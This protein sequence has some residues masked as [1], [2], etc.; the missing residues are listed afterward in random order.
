MARPRWQRSTA[1]SASHATW[2]YSRMFAAAHPHLARGPDRGYNRRMRKRLF[3]I[4]GTALAYRSFF[5][6]Q[7]AGRAPL[8][9]REG[10]PTAATYGF[11]TTLRA[12][13]EREQPDA[14]AIAFDGPTADLER[15]KLYPEYKSTREKMPDEMVAQLADIKEA[16]EGFG[17]RLIDSDGHEADDVIATMALRAKRA[18]MEVFLVTAD[19]DFLQIVDDDVKLWNLRSSTAKPEIVDA[20]ACEAKWGVPPTAMGDLLALMGDSSDNVPGVPKVGEKTAVELLKQFGSLAGVYERLDEVKKP[21]IKASLAENRHLADLSRKLVTLHTDVP[22]D[23]QPEDIPPPHPDAEK[24]RPLFQ[25][26]DFGN[27]LKDLA[28]RPAPQ[29]DVAQTYRLAKTPAELDELLAALR[30]APHVAIAAE[31]SGPTIRQRRLLGLA[32]ATAPGV[33]TYV[34]LDGAAATGGR[35]AALAALAPWLADA[36]PR[37]IAHDAK[38]LMAA[39]RTVGLTLAGIVDDV[40]LASYCCDAG[41]ADH[42]LDALALREFAFK[43]TSAKELLGTGKKQRTFAELDPM[44]VANFVCEEADLTLRLW[45]PLR[46]KVTASGV[47]AIYRELELPLLPVL[48]DMEWEGIA[49][50]E[51]HL[52]GVAREMQARIESLELRVHERAGKPFNL[53]SPQQLGVV[54]FDELEVHRLAD[55]QKP[56]RTATG[57]YKTDHEVLEKLAKH[58][59]VPQ[60]VLEWRQLTKLKGTYVDSL[61]TLIDAASHRVHTT[62]NQAVAATG[63]LSSEDPNLQNIPIRTEEGRKVRS[64][65]VARGT[66]W[67]LLSADYSQIE[68]RILAH[69]SGDK[70]MVE[71]FTRGEDI[72]ART[73]AIV[74]GLLPAMVTPELRNQAKVINYGLMYGMG[75]SRLAAETGMK[76]PEAKK[77]IDTYF[78]ALPGVKRYLDGSLQQAR[79]KKEV[80]TMFGRRRPLPDI[81]STNA[82]QRIAAENMAVNTPIQGAAADIIKRAMLAVHADLRQRGLQAKLLLQV[83]DE[84]VLDVPDDERSAVEQLVRDAMIG[85]A[86][87]HVPLEVAVGCGR[88]WLSA[89]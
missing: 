20:A 31:A 4:D 48:L 74:H 79:E 44:L 54:L 2:I 39:L 27:L 11:C 7:G 59:E 62:L 6:F 32:F 78:R 30:A 49:L 73:A 8:T 52:A 58:H 15:T 66:G 89:H 71:S 16:T 55:L 38:K 22:L 23:V 84:L 56:K 36:S 75:A 17:L 83:H 21:A 10:Q 45:E 1:E 82:M 76:P 80:W 3:L 41:V 24:L 70:A 63:R 61:P 34:P 18:G 12:L 88:T 47:E 68:L 64:A 87:L 26:L 50:D 57:Q 43:K 69:V 65:F 86:Q 51:G 9:N 81:D 13:L 29:A 5:A 72:H 85:A 40:M 14:V 33:S 28:S 46:A 35:D 77:F 25:R 37:K 53:G 42:D 67:Q 60:L 19:K